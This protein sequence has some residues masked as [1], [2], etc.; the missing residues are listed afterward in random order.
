MPDRSRR[1]AHGAAD[2]ALLRRGDHRLGALLERH[3]DD[4]AAIHRDIGDGADAFGLHLVGAG[5]QR[6]EFAD[7]AAILLLAARAQDHPRPAGGPQVHGQIDAVDDAAAHDAEAGAEAAIAQLPAPAG[8]R[9]IDD[10]LVA[11]V[12]DE[13]GLDNTGVEQLEGVGAGLQ[14][15]EPVGA[16]GRHQ[17][18]LFPRFARLAGQEH[19]LPGAALH[20]AAHNAAGEQNRGPRQI[21]VRVAGWILVRQDDF[22]VN[23]RFDDAEG[24][25]V[26]RQI[27]ELVPA[28]SIG[29]ADRQP[30]VGAH[31]LHGQR[32]IRA[33]ADG[34]EQA[35]RQ[36]GIP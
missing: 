34:A 4:A 10:Q 7:I 31:E 8:H 27:G 2:D 12:E 22:L 13:I 6:R 30:T 19:N 21:E 29:L 1:A 11:P 15:E 33:V 5:S 35:A 17:L 23:A 25:T 20:V 26:E 32:Q 16:V 14:F 36:P 3:P 9:Q 24:E 28:I 18:L